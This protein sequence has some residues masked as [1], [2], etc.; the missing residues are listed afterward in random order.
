MCYNQSKDLTGLLEG[1]VIMAANPNPNGGETHERPIREPVWRYRGYELRPSEFATAMVHFY[2]GE[3]Q[4]ANTWRNRLDATTNW[5]IVTTAA[6]ISFALAESTNT[7]AVLLIN[8]VLILI[9]LWIEARRYRYFELFSYRVRLL[10]TDFFAAMLVP[11]FQPSADWAETLATSLLRPKF[12][13]SKWEAIGRRLR[14]N[15]LAILGILLLVWVFKLYSLPVPALSYQE[16]AARAAIGPVTGMIVLEVVGIIATIL[17]LTAMATLRLHDATGEILEQPKVFQGLGIERV[18]RPSV[19]DR[20]YGTGVWQRPTARRDEFMT[21]VITDKG[22]AV[23]EKVMQDLNRGVTAL[24]GEGMYTQQA[25]QVL[26]CA[27]TETEIDDLKRAVH[28]VDP[29]G[30]VIVLPASEI[31]GRGFQPFEE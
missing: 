20:V 17:I 16:F 4:R 15:Y 31:A 25:R 28:A 26:L 29:G 23:A 1:S 30:F 13:I 14:R 9:F 22:N 19:H 11:P 10:E 7:H 27:L 12:P 2:R 5:A 8:M 6:V 24:N 21:M 18:L 3:I